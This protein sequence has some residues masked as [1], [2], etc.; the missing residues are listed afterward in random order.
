MINITNKTKVFVFCPPNLV[1]GGA[2]LLHQ[3]VHYLRTHGR[4]A[5]IYYYGAS[6]DTK[7][8]DDY[9]CYNIKVIKEI[10]DEDH[11]ILVLPEV[12]FSLSDDY[13]NIQQLFW[14]L[15]VDN[16]FVAYMNILN[17]QDITKWNIKKGRE[18]LKHHLYRLFIK[19]RKSIFR[20]K[21]IKQFCSKASLH[22]YQSEYAHRFLL[23]IGFVKMWALKDFINTQHSEGLSFDNRED[24]VL[25]NP[26]KGYEITKQIIDNSPH[27]KWVAIENMNRNEVVDLMRRSKVY[28]DFGNHPGKD[29]LPRE[30]ALNGC[31]IITGKRG[32]SAYFE[33][34]PIDEQFK[35]EDKELD[36]NSVIVKIE[37]VLDNF[38]FYSQCFDSYREIIAREY[39]DF[40]NQV[41]TIFAI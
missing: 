11:N 7:V 32:A 17:V 16:F 22:L 21:S 6:E 39:T 18:L 12:M 27:I 37:S 40:E 4:E 19:G 8:P 33:D 30:C 35:F 1:T 26:K 15:S 3:L 41:K 5:Y 38:E 28:V 23:D 31:C 24:I 10:I 14:W 9:L 13:K 25:Y 36:I 34:V 20:T 29:R 2:E